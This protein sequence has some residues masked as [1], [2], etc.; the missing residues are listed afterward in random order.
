MIHKD[1]NTTSPQAKVECVSDQAA[2][3]VVNNVL[4]VGKT[5]PVQNETEEFLFIIDNS[6]KV[7]GFYKD[8]FK[9]I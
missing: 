8:Y 3:Y 9:K 2:K 6:G 4:T 5:Y 7:G 1:W